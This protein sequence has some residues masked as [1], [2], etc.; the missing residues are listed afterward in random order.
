[1]KA[2]RTILSVSVLL[3]FLSACTVHHRDDD[4]YFRSHYSDHHAERVVHDVYR[5]NS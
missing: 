4:M 3:S 2:L 1:M 5:T